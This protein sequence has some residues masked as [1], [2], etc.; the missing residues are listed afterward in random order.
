MGLTE[1]TNSFFIMKIT[2]EQYKYKQKWSMLIHAAGLACFVLPYV[3]NLIVTYLL[4]EKKRPEDRL[5]YHQGLAA[6]NFQLSMSIYFG[7]ASILLLL[8]VGIFFMIALSVV[9]VLTIGLA[10]LKAHDLEVYQ[11]PFN[12]NLVKDKFPKENPNQA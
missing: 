10:V 6:F 2:P 8:W 5:F 3:G 11:Y 12:L 9:Q 1:N 7:I 4:W